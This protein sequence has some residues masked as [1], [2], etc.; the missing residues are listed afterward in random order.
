MLFRSAGPR[1]GGGGASLSIQV[2][3]LG[4]ARPSVGG[5]SGRGR[6]RSHPARAASRWWLRGGGGRL[7]CGGVAAGGPGD[8][9]LDPASRSGA[10]P[11]C[12]WRRAEELGGAVCAHG[13][14]GRAGVQSSRCGM[15]LGAHICFS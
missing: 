14:R 11:A 12:R 9:D 5:A 2:A 15:L 1:D 7:C 8:L 13:L 6:W 3:G 4:D 10:A